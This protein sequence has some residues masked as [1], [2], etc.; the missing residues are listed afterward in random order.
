[1][2][3]PQVKRPAAR[4]ILSLGPPAALL[5]LCVIWLTQWIPE[6]GGGLP[7]ASVVGNA[8]PVAEPLSTLKLN[9]SPVPG[10]LSLPP[11][12]L[13]GSGP[14]NPPA[15][16][17]PPPDSRTT[18]SLEDLKAQMPQREDGTFV[19]EVPTLHFAANDPAARRVME[20]QRV[21]TVAQIAPGRTDKSELRLVRLLT[22][23]CSADARPF[24]ITASIAG[25][26]PS[27]ANA[28]WVKVRGRIGY[29][30]VWDGFGAVL[31]VESVTETS[32]PLDWILR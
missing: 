30:R 4:L 26:P 3:S 18:F 16:H 32:A 6:T 13:A 14:V 17:R 27:F 12:T 8:P 19:I 9:S 29:H 5:S 28:A 23:C 24:H 31:H 10:V 20:G 22:R 2:N 11:A 25:K 7:V 15:T 1:M 21:E